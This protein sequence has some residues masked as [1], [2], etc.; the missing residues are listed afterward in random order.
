M[1]GVWMPNLLCRNSRDFSPN[2]KNAEEDR[3]GDYIWKLRPEI[4]DALD[5][6]N[7]QENQQG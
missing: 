1:T 6:L 3:K 2:G 5:E 4:A 7:E